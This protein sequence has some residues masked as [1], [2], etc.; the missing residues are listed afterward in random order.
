V[1]PNADYGR[2]I[3]PVACAHVSMSAQFHAG[4]PPTVHRG[5]GN[6]PRCRHWSTVDRCTLSRAAISTAPTGSMSSVCP[7]KLFDLEVHGPQSVAAEVA[8]L[9]DCHGDLAIL[10]NLLDCSGD[11]ACLRPP[12]RCVEHMISRDHNG[13]C[14]AD[15]WLVRC[16]VYRLPRQQSGVKG[17]STVNLSPNGRSEP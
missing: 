8:K 5:A 7:H 2:V 13:D 9:V 4:R 16:H 1:T 12:C 6:S 3:R 11:R 17:I 14:F 15:F 10:K